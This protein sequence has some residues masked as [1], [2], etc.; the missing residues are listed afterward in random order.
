M[1]PMAFAALVWP[2]RRIWAIRLVELLIALIV[3][4]FVIV[5]VLSLA[6]AAF[7]QSGVDSVTRTLTAMALL[8]LSTFAPWTMLRLLPFTEVAAS[9]AAALRQEVPGLPHQRQGSANG[10]DEG[11]SSNPGQSTSGNLTPDAAD[12]GDLV[13]TR[14][15]TQAAEVFGRNGGGGSQT[16]SADRGGDASSP[17]PGSDHSDPSARPDVPQGP[18]TAQPAPAAREERLPGMD[19]IWQAEN[20][21]WP[22]LNLG[23]GGW[24]GP[25]EYAPP[26]Q[27]GAPADAAPTDGATPA[28]HPGKPA[29]AANEVS[30]TPPLATPGP[31]VPVAEPPVPAAEPS[32][33]TAE[34]PVRAAEP[35][36]PAA[37]PPVP[38]A[39]PSVRAA[40]PPAPA[41]G[42]AGP[43]AGATPDSVPEP[44]AAGLVTPDPTLGDANPGRMPS[45]PL[46][47]DHLNEG[48][49]SGQDRTQL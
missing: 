25:T 24:G 16:P 45:D 9:A 22:P 8:L 12:P 7:G 13:A 31:P 6:G 30:P 3:S 38:A 14:L 37:E 43:G 39:E 1:L 41:P 40:E 26:G 47:P 36:A 35:P 29:P 4:K 10:G 34:S 17:S 49:T 32:V 15:R 2:A 18:E 42:L 46:A 5:A 33:R 27:S 48:Q 19:P 11:Q 44:Q 23:P 28:T 21:A 20:G